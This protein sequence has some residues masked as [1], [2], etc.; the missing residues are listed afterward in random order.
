[1]HVTAPKLTE[2]DIDSIARD[3]YGTLDIIDVHD[4]WDNAG[5][6]WEGYVDPNEYAADLFEDAMTEFEDALAGYHQQKKHADEHIYLLGVLKG[7]YDFAHTSKNEYKDWVVD[8]PEDFFGTFIIN[9]LKCNPTHDQHK[10]HTDLKQRFPRW[11]KECDNC[12]ARFEQKD[13]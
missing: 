8:I 11:T 12:F 1:M 10:L 9:F 2:E 3:V 5:S 7:I 13:V 4:V 6:K